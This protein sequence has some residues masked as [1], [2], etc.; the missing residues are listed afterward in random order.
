MAL[1]EDL[2]IYRSMYNLLRLLMQARNQFD[3]AYKYVVGDRM[4][5]TALGC[6]LS[7]HRTTAR[8]RL[9]LPYAAITLT[10]PFH[11]PLPPR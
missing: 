10:P 2:N 11:P 1:T 4:I 9:T 6:S 5:D 7:L 3:K 8:P